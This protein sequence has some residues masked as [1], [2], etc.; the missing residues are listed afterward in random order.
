MASR[1]VLTRAS[2]LSHSDIGCKMRHPINEIN[3]QCEGTTLPQLQK[4]KPFTSE[5]PQDTQ[6]S[7]N[8]AGS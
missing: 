3:V 2:T 6:L 1:S 5:D 7:T 8:Y 4:E